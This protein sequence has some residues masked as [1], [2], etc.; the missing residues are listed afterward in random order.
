VIAGT[1]SIT[2]RILEKTNTLKMIS[3]VGIG[4]DSVDLLTAKKRGIEVCYT[5]D[6]PSPAVAEL[7]IAL[8]LSLLRQVHISNTQ[9]HAGIWHRILGR[10]LADCT[11]GIIGTGRIGKRVIQHLG[12]FS[13]KRIMA[14]DVSAEQVFHGGENVEW[15]TKRAI[16]E[17]AD[18]ISLHVP[19][20]KNTE[21]L[22][23]RSELEIMKNDVLLI[24]TARGGIINEQQLFD[25]MQADHIAGVAIDV[26]EEEPYIGNLNKLDRCL[27]TPHMGS[28]S[29][30]CR[31]Q[32]EIEATEEAVRYLTGKPLRRRVPET[33]YQLRENW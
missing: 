32:M 29:E 8:M 4:L 17:E 11:I 7:T 25:V 22:I 3:R 33:E 5:P 6:A 23:G 21:N 31:S 24:N 12:G 18:I 13:V 19:L 16:Y 1:E 14:N 20:T 9:M 27:L 2:A 10:R 15:C 30:D 28:M 26:F